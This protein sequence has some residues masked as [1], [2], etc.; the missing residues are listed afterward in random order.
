MDNGISVYIG[1]DNTLEENIELIRQAEACGIRRIF[2]SL[3]IPESNKDALKKEFR[4]LLSVA[5]RENVDVVTDISPAV[6]D[7]LDLPDLSLEGFAAMGITTLRLDYGFSAEDIAGMSHNSLGIKLQLNASTAT[8]E[9]LESLASAKVD[10]NTLEASHNFFPRENTGL[11]EAFFTA[12]NQLLHKYG[13]KVACFIPSFN[14]PRSPIGA[15]LP[16]LEQHRKTSFD[17]ALR[18]MLA[19]NVDSVFVGD[20][21]PSSDELKLLGELQDSTHIILRPELW[22]SKPG[23]LALL[24]KEYTTRLDEARDVIRT[25]E[26]RLY[27]KEAGIHLPPEQCGPRKRGYITLDNINYGRYQGELQIIKTDLPSDYRV[28]IVASL[29]NNE[30]QLIDYLTPGRGFK[31][32]F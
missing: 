13:V 11:E 12:K 18:H 14:R 2:T 19:L 9:L 7:I 22:T 1:L 3:H 6:M 26:S 24:H 16:T 31:F 15:G 21:L 10:M 8:P 29:S 5:K 17:F 25:Q 32:L 4:Q 30:L 28:N 27:L 20:S 23:I